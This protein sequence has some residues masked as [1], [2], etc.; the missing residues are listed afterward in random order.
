MTLSAGVDLGGTKVLAALVDDH[1]KIM[2]RVTGSTDVEAGTASVIDALEELLKVGTH[3]PQAVGVG[4][5]AYVEHP[6]GRVV[7]APNLEYDMPDVE[8]AVARA[9]G[10][11][12][13]VENDA[14]AA[15]WAEYVYGAGRGGGDMV[16][17]TIG[18]GVGG[19]IVIAGNLYRGSRGFA[20][21]FGHMT[22]VEGGPMCAC[23]Q[24]GC[25]E[26]LASG[27]AIGRMAREG[28]GGAPD[29]ILSE[30]SGGNPAKIT[31]ALVSEAAH[32]Y[33][34]YAAGIIERAGRALGVGLASL[35]NAFD[36]GLIVIGGG[37]ASAGDFLLAP[38]RSELRKRLADRREPPEV[39]LGTLANDAGVIGAAA[40]G[41]LA[42]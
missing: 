21:E 13:A 5:A 38:A 16:M 3:R 8:Q 41:R 29:S 35:T 30:L 23:G 31:G 15:A 9:F 19:G 11:P 20:A 32:A 2:D 42:I 1:G 7:F 33:D 28:I 25:L 24:R 26:A 4:V 22:L 37:G 14:N 36:P 6:S 12:V 27:T 18:T 40:L 34:E 39:V 10:I 17:L